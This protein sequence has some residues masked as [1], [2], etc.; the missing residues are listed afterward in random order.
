MT[1]NRYNSDPLVFRLT[2]ATVMLSIGDVRG[3][4]EVIEYFPNDSLIAWL[5][6]SITKVAGEIVT[7]R[8]FLLKAL[9]LKVEIH[10][11]KSEYRRVI[12]LFESL[13]LAFESNTGGLSFVEYMYALSSKDFDSILRD[14]INSMALLDF[15]AYQSKYC[16]LLRDASIHDDVFWDY[17]KVNCQD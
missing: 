4:E 6:S 16:Q 12:D 8:P 2:E 10:E 17:V 15:P 7:E 11:S 1:W 3:A 14:A 13:E 9:A 5:L